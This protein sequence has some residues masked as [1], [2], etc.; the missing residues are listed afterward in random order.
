MADIHQE[1]EDFQR[2]CIEER[3]ARFPQDQVDF[4]WRIFENS[5]HGHHVPK[6][7]LMQALELLDR[8]IAELERKK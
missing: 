3:L 8:S 7:K 2:K 5:G 4:F 1:I 6:E